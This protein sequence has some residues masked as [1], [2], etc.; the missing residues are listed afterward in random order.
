LSG[1]DGAVLNPPDRERVSRRKGNGHRPT[2][3]RYE[4]RLLAAKNRGTAVK[5]TLAVESKHA[6]DDFELVAKVCEVDKFNIL[7]KLPNDKE[8]WLSK[9]FIACTEVLA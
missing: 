5:F 4:Q 9:L 2:L 7:V 1:T 6:N 3:D 8:V